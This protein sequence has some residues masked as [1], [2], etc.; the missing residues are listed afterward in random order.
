M[1]S[2][3]IS[4]PCDIVLRNISGAE[5]IPIGDSKVSVS[6]KRL[7]SDLLGLDRLLT[8]FGFSTT[9]IELIVSSCIFSITSISVTP[10]AH[11]QL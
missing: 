6:A 9:T 10:S 1:L 7:Y 3:I 5:F 8:L 4:Q 11:I 2:M